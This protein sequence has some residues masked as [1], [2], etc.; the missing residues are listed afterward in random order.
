MLGSFGL[1]GIPWME[2]SWIENLGSNKFQLHKL[3]KEAQWA[4]VFGSTTF[5]LNQDGYED[6]LIVGNDYGVEVNQGRLDA[7]Q[8]VFYL[9][10]NSSYKIFTNL[11]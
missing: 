7:L 1:C 10:C 9:P 2:T 11:H 5:D 8:E 3:P 4:P 6:L